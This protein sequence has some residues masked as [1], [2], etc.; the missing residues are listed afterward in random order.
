MFGGG[1][2]APNC[3]GSAEYEAGAVGSMAAKGGV[4]PIGVGAAEDA[5]IAGGDVVPGGRRG[6][7]LEAGCRG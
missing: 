2:G 5:E 4:F 3:G 1:N 7:G 6:A